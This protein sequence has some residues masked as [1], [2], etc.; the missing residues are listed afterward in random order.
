[1]LTVTQRKMVSLSDHDPTSFTNSPLRKAALSK[2]LEPRV[3]NYM[4]D[5]SGVALCCTGAG[6]NVLRHV[7]SSRRRDVENF[8]HRGRG[9]S[10]RRPGL[11]CLH[12]SFLVGEGVRGGQIGSQLS[13]NVWV[14]SLE[15]L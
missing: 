3:V 14:R 15:S 7:D 4:E 12:F 1:M 6:F 13:F 5:P 9:A 2:V 8:P 11:L 10:L